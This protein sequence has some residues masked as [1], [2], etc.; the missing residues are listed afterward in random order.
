[1]GLDY[2]DLYLAHWPVVFKPVSKEAL[3]NATTGPDT[4]KADKG[5]MAQ[6]GTDDAVLDWEHTSSNL[7]TQAGKTDCYSGVSFGH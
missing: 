4:N 2:V 5:I 7:A 3:E 1:M 6:P